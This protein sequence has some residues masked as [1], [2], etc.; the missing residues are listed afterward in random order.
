MIFAKTVFFVAGLWGL[1]VLTPLYFT[2]DLVGRL[3]PPPISHPDFYY[4]F[5][6]VAGLSPARKWSSAG[7]NETVRTGQYVNHST[8][9]RREIASMLR[10]VG[11]QLT[12][13]SPLEV[14][15][16]CVSFVVAAARSLGATR[17]TTQCLVRAVA[18][19]AGAR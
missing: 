6:G 19:Q 18:A 2:F 17:A 9:H 7:T 14:P 10:Q 5:I 1:V 4:G 16:P 8:Y 13:R 11:A 3:Y 12:R 15:G